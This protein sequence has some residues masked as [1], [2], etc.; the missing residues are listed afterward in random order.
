MMSNQVST[1]QFASIEQPDEPRCDQAEILLTKLRKALRKL[2]DGKGEVWQS[3]IGYF[4]KADWTRAV[5]VLQDR[6]W[7]IEFQD[8]P[9]GGGVKIES[10]WHLVVT[11]RHLSS[12]SRPSEECKEGGR[13]LVKLLYALW[14]IPWAVIVSTLSFAKSIRQ[15]KVAAVQKRFSLRDIGERLEHWIIDLNDFGSFLLHAAV[16]A[17]FIAV[18]VAGCV[19]LGFNS[20]WVVFEVLVGFV[21]GESL[22]QAWWVH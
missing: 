14:L 20:D 16:L 13:A 22:I 15:P 12:R 17:V 19:A 2:P 7:I 4:P 9:T 6:G 1:E 10:D 5:R 18:P 11:G 8:S 3:R 21:I